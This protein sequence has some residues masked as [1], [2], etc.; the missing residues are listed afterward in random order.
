[1][2]SILVSKS[3]TLDIIE[4]QDFIDIQQFYL[5]AKNMLEYSEA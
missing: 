1:M 5:E 4:N 3:R 2:P